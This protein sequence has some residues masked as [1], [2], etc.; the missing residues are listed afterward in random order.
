MEKP[1]PTIPCYHEAVCSGCLFVGLTGNR[2]RQLA[3]RPPS[4]PLERIGNEFAKTRSVV[5]SEIRMLVEYV[6]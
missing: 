2:P 3:G 5:R 6:N 4:I 1:I